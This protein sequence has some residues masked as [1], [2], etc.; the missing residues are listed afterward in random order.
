MKKVLRRI[1]WGSLIAGF[2]LGIVMVPATITF[3]HFTSTE[4]FCGNS[5]HAMKWVANDPVYINSAHKKNDSGVI[6]QC[7]DCH[8]PKGIMAETWAHIRDGTADLIASLSNDFTDPQKWEVRRQ[9]LAHKI[10][11]KMIDDNS[12]NCRSCHQLALQEHKKERVARQHELGERNN[13]TCIQCHFNLV[14]APVGPTN[15]EQKGL[16]LL[17]DYTRT[18]STEKE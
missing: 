13:V 10:R 14:H 3:N 17:P 8:L 7:K 12:S 15:K 9:A 4:N 6:A 18:S 2:I 5:C 16:R 1:A 11:K